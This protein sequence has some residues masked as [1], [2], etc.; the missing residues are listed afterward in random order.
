[1]GGELSLGGNHGIDP[2]LFL[3]V[4]FKKLRASHESSLLSV[5]MLRS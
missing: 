1:M 4:C 5:K 2:I 3:F